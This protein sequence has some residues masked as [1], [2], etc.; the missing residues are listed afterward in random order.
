MKKLTAIIAACLL[1]CLADSS[2]AKEWRGIVPLR[3]TR[4]D[5]RKMLGKPHGECNIFDDYFV[6]EDFVSVLYADQYC[7]GPLRYYWGNYTVAP[8]AVLSVTVRFEHGIPLADYKIPSMKKL[9]KGKPDSIL[10]VDYFDAEQGIEYSVRDGQVVAV[11][12][13]PSATDAYLR[14]SN[15]DSSV[16][17]S[18]MMKY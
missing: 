17:Y 12:Y 11:E 5:V 9:R 6:D 2:L 1:V 7:D 3:T 14:C 15:T 8:G 18:I 16:S 13:G 4:E 10:T